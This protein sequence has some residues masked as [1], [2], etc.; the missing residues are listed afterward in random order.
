MSAQSALARFPG[1]SYDDSALLEA[2]ERFL[3]FRER[4]PEFAEQEN[5]SAF[6]R[7]I[8][9]T[10]AQKHLMVGKWYGRHQHSESAGIYYREVVSRWPDS[11]AAVECGAGCR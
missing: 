9:E 10:L 5:I 7:R 1:V 2:R 3:S 8:D 6:V 11:V 4:Y